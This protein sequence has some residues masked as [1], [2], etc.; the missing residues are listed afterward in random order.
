MPFVERRLKPLPKTFAYEEESPVH[1]TRSWTFSD[2]EM[3]EDAPEESG[4]ESIPIWPDTDDEEQMSMNFVTYR[5]NTEQSTL[6]T[7]EGFFDKLAR[8]SQTGP[9]VTLPILPPVLRNDVALLATNP[10]FSPSCGARTAPANS[11]QAPMTPSF[12]LDGYGSASPMS[13]CRSKAKDSKQRSSRPETKATANGEIT[14][15]MI[16]N[17][18]SHLT[19]TELLNELNKLG[20]SKLYDFCYLPR[21]FNVAENKGALSRHNFAKV[22]YF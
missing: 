13:E 18:P 19:Q 20:L 15:L 17:L 9:N 4:C 10:Q 8:R 5:K 3:G 14:T 22:H 16:R 12:K 1:R 2:Y 6:S 21:D 7:L 11:L